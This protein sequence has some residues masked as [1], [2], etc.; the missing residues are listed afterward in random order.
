MAFDAHA[1]SLRREAMEEAMA[2]VS[3][4]HAPSH[5]AHRKLHLPVSHITLTRIAVLAAC[6]AFW[7]GVGMIASAIIG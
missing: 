4:N 1:S 6:G 5:G 7:L 2:Y 3:T